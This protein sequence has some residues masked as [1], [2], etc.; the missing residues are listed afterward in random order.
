[1]DK[2]I[3]CHT[4]T[5]GALDWEIL[6]A[7]SAIIEAVASN[8]LLKPNIIV[9]SGRG[10]Q[11]Y[12]IFEKSIPY[13][14]S[15]KSV[16]INGLK[17]R[18]NI[19]NTI[20]FQ[21][22]NILN[23]ADSSLTLDTKVNDISRIVR[24]PG[25]MNTNANRVAQIL[26]YDDDYYCFSDFYNLKMPTKITVERKARTTTTPSFSCA[27]HNIRISEIKALQKYRNYNC[28]GC[29]E[30]MCFI[31]YNSAVQIHDKATAYDMLVNFRNKFDEPDGVSDS[32]LKTLAKCVDENKGNNYKGFYML[33]KDW[34]IQQLNI[35]QNEIEELG[36]F[37]LSK[38]E[39]T[40]QQNRIDKRKQKTQVIDLANSGMSRQA[41]AD[42][43]GISK[44]TVQNIL[45]DA[46]KTRKYKKLD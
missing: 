43:V 3:D 5:D 44:R 41:I 25:T 31:F 38:R 18:E 4:Q 6:H 33:T 29:R 9:N 16:N 2:A 10:L 13:R 12:Y 32:Q 23:D 40:K 21:L 26:N 30:L 8:V 27:L 20:S 39:L 45:K 11:L 37:K 19:I 17:V 1:M 14:L 42:T 46:G 24:I 28:K 35:T 36:L 15:D 22:K 34:I 7:Y